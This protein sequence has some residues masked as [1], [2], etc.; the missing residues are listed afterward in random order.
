MKSAAK[1]IT[2]EFL[3]QTLQA[4]Q[5]NSKVESLENRIDKIESRTEIR[6][7]K[8]VDKMNNINSRIFPLTY[9]KG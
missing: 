7:E 1:R 6:F 2:R 9:F 5:P 8:L 4:K 3:V